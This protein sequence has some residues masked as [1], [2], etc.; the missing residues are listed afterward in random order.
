MNAFRNLKKTGM[1]KGF[2]AGQTD[3]GTIPI[4]GIENRRNVFCRQRIPIGGTIAAAVPAGKIASLCDLKK[5]PSKM[6]GMTK[7]IPVQGK[8]FQL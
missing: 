6:R 8:L 5:Q 2:S 3:H 4:N 1:Q 7:M